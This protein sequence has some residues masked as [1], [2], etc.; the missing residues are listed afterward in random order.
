MTLAS[1]TTRSTMPKG[2]VRSAVNAIGVAIVR[3]EYPAGSILPPEEA[4]GER[5]GLSRPGLR[6]AVKVLSGK[7]LVRTV[8]R[9]GSRV[10][11]RGEWNYLDPDVL[12]WHLTDPANMPQFLSDIREMR[13]LLEPTATAMAATRATQAD[14]DLL[15][16]LAAQL[17]TDPKEA[18]IEA[19]ISFHVTMLRASGNRLMAGLCPAMEVLLRAYFLAMWRLDPEGPEQ[20]TAENLHQ[21]TAKAIAERDPKRARRYAN[22]MLSVTASEIERVLGSFEPLG[23]TSKRAAEP[24]SDGFSE[25]VRDLT[26]IFGAF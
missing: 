16:S 7:G 20:K 25:R 18:T 12:T 8:R 14:V 1:R 11:G 4:L 21:L 19:D 2:L 6:E 24:S 13:L 9:Y 17:P 5:Y 15:V 26:H 23:S 10:C 22:A 3:G